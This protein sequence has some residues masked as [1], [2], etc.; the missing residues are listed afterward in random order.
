MLKMEQPNDVTFIPTP[1]MSSL[2]GTRVTR[3]S[4]FAQSVSM[5]LDLFLIELKGNWTLF[6]PNR[7]VLD[8]NVELV[9]R[10]DYQLWRMIG[11][12]VSAASV[13]SPHTGNLTI[14]LTNGLL[15]V[16]DAGAEGDGWRVTG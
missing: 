3:I 9:S 12:D 4:L 14:S 7:E 16:A 8:R 1:P 10:E 13:D 6:G 2:R 15:L 11:G 5:L